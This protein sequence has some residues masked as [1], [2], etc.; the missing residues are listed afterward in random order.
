VSRE[1]ALV[2]A[3]HDDHEG[4]G[5]RLIEP[6]RHRAVPPLEDVLARDVG[7]RLVGLVGV[8]HHHAVA[9]LAGHRA[10]AEVA[11]R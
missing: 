9:A 7:L 8:V 4:T 6:G 3:L 10:L 2:Q 1:V 11:M 5:L